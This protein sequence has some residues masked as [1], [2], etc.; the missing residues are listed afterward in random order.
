MTGPMIP[1]ANRKVPNQYKNDTSNTGIATSTGFYTGVVK[2]N[3][4][5]QKMGRLQV[6]VEEFGGDPE[7][8]SSWITVSYASPFA[9]TTSIYEQGNNVK[10]YE[11]TV[12]S[13][14]FWAVPPDLNARVVVGFLGG[15]LDKGLWFACLYQQGT[16]VSVPGIPARN[17]YGGENKPAAPKNK[18]DKDTDYEKFV[19]HKPMSNA[20]N[21]QGLA[22]DSVRGTTSSSASRESPSKVLGILT[23]GQ[24]QFVMDDG[25]S[26]GNNKL[27][28]LRTTNGTQILLDDTAGHVYLITKTGETWLELSADGRV[29]LYGTGDI[30]VRSEKNIN[31]YADADI[32]IEARQAINMKSNSGNIN[33]EAGLDLSTSAGSNTVITSGASSN[34]NS[35]IG[36]YE[37]AGVIHMNGPAAAAASPL[38]V[39]TLATNQTINSSICSTVPEHE[40]WAGHS[41]SINPVGPGNLQMQADP[42]PGAQPRQSTET[43]PRAPLADVE[44][45]PGITEVPIAEISTSTSAVDKIKEHNGYSPVNIND[46]PGISAGFGSPLVEKRPPIPLDPA[47][48]ALNKATAESVQAALDKLPLR[49]AGN[50]PLTAIKEGVANFA[51]NVKNTLTG[52]STLSSIIGFGNLGGMSNSKIPAV[53]ANTVFATGATPAIANQLLAA[54]ITKSE[55]A[56]RGILA[57]QG[58]NKVPQNVFD[59][60][61]SYHNQVGDIS[62]AYV[63]GEKISLISA[64]KS[65]DWATAASFIAADERDRPRR[66]Q[67]AT[68]M[69]YNDYGKIKTEQDIIDDGLIKAKGLVSKDR[70]NQQTGEPATAQQVV[71]LASTYLDQTGTPLPGISTATSIAVSE[72]LGVETTDGV[73]VDSSTGSINKALKRQAGPWPY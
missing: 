20:L 36:H 15:R 53:A 24:H 19:E 10:D 60:L 4:D 16:Q 22:G 28:R 27:I 2:R 63:K 32:N 8:D 72:N 11:D 25:D 64:F 69:A 41:G 37:T 42:S 30:S 61:V 70:L 71:A 65:N 44:P 17:T 54:D 29:H 49:P 38:T 52:N 51:A 67:E 13:Y 50:N 55:T 43:D 46:G 34:I 9:G 7:D 26:D 66:I 18:K 33:L 31:L 40:P 35:G 56:V 1:N 57:G 12:K 59:A 5:T 3:D 45:Q 73:I 58:V 21:Q 23:P 62:Y 68:M 48:A 39:T 6:W 14:G 47:T